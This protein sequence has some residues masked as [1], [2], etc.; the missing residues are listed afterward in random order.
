MPFIS[1][2]RVGSHEDFQLGI[3]IKAIARLHDNLS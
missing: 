2:L 1:V 3:H